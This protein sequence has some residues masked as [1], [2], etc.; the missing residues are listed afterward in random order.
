[1]Q[2][3]TTP[4]IVP[5][6]SRTD[7][8]CHAISLWIS[9]ISLFPD[10]TLSW[11]PHQTTFPIHLT[12]DSFQ[13]CLLSL[14]ILSKSVYWLR[15]SWQ[16]HQTTLGE[17]WPDFIRGRCRGDQLHSMSMGAKQCLYFFNSGG[18]Y[19]GGSWSKE[20]GFPSGSNHNHRCKVTFTMCLWDGFLL[21]RNPV[22]QLMFFA[23]S[24]SNRVQR[25]V[26][27]NYYSCR[28]AKA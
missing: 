17:N 20:L 1:M 5:L 13:V 19:L 2:I 22:T 11:K 12:L 8:S 9:W 23:S 27:F 26:S 6:L 18:W 14:W 25:F 16:P 3:S 15:L 4:Q 10:W 28:S 24:H 7:S 21:G